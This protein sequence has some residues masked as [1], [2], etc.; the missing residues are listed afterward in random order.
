M[1][2]TEVAS[3]ASAATPWILGADFIDDWVRIASPRIGNMLIPAAAVAFSEGT[4]FQRLGRGAKEW[5][6]FTAFP[7]YF[8]TKF[9]IQMTSGVIGGGI[10]AMQ[11]MAYTNPHGNINY[12]TRT[13]ESMLNKQLG[14]QMMDYHRQMG[15]GGHGGLGSEAARLH[16]I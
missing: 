14:L 5:A 11:N 4:L 2:V 12:H 16:R 13:Q 1:A 3:A 15:L 8:T 7:S 10:S 9:A 6:L